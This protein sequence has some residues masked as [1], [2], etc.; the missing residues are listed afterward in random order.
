MPFSNFY[1]RL[2]HGTK[3]PLIAKHIKISSYLALSL[4]EPA[5][6]NSFLSSLLAVSRT[7]QLFFRKFTK[8]TAFPHLW[9]RLF[10]DV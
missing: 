2:F 9:N 3:A 8:L 7:F 1:I 5:V 10:L 6:G 4:V